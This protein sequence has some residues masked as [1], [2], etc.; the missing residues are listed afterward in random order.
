MKRRGLSSWP[1]KFGNALKLQRLSPCT[2]Q[3]CSGQNHAIRQIYDQVPAGVRRRAEPGGR[4]GQSVHRAAASVACAAQPAGRRRRIAAGACRR[5]CRRPAHR[6]QASHRAPAQG[7]GAGRRSQRLARALQ[8]AQ[9]DRQGSAETRRPVH[10]LRNVPAGA[11]QRQGRN[12]PAAE[13]DRAAAGRRSS[14]RSTPCAA[15]RR[16]RIRKP[17]GSAKR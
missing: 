15:A 13:A 2:C 7:G 17:R 9:S 6:A 4:Q 12:R 10:R 8:P 3:P 5:Q 11:G 16:C 1:Q 14:R